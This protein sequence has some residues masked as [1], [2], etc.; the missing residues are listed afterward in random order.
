MYA[1]E[2]VKA[3]FVHSPAFNSILLSEKVN[4]V[5]GQRAMDG[6]GIKVLADQR[7]D[8]IDEWNESIEAF[9]CRRGG[10]FGA[11]FDA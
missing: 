4:S 10:Q 11:Y 2:L 8:E 1:P 9:L 3:L 5:H 6:R 7:E